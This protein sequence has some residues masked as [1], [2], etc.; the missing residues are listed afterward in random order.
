MYVYTMYKITDDKQLINCRS[1]LAFY[2]YLVRTAQLVHSTHQIKLPNASL[3]HYNE[4]ADLKYT[5]DHW[6]Y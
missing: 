2:H 5:C 6:K 4:Y 1:D 3:H